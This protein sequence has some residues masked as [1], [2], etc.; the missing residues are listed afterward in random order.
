VR[1]DLDSGYR[2]ATLSLSV[3]VEN[4]GRE[5]APVSVEG[6]LLDDRGNTAA[7]L[8]IKMQVSPDARGGR[9]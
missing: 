2:D 3:T 5:P 9:G 7:A 6:T 8:A 1:T 4:A